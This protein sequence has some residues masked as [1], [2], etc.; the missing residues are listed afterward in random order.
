M[1]TKF[2]YFLCVLTKLGKGEQKLTFADQ[3]H[4]F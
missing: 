3:L 4:K 2:Y 1:N